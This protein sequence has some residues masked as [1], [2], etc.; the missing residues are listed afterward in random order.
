[1]IDEL[2]DNSAAIENPSIGASAITI[3]FG[4][5]RDNKRDTEMII[6]KLE[7]SSNFWLKLRGR[8]RF[9][10]RTQ[11]S[12]M[13]QRS[14][15]YISPTYPKVRSPHLFISQLS[16]LLQIPGAAASID[17]DTLDRSLAIINSAPPESLDF[18][19]DALSDRTVT[20]LLTRP[21]ETM[22]PKV[23]QCFNVAAAIAVAVENRVGELLASS[24]DIPP[25][26]LRKIVKV[27]HSNNEEV[28]ARYRDEVSK[29]VNNDELSAR[30]RVRQIHYLTGLIPLSYMDGM[31]DKIVDLVLQCGPN[32]SA[33]LLGRILKCID[34]E[35]VVDR[36][37][38]FLDMC[39]L[40]LIRDWR[41]MK[42]WT[43]DL[44]MA[45]RLVQLD[46]FSPQL[47]KT[48]FSKEFMKNLD[49]RREL[50]NERSDND[51][52]R[53]LCHLNRLVCIKYP[54]YRIPWFHEKYCLENSKFISGNGIR[55]E[56]VASE[57]R[58]DVLMH[59]QR[60]VGGPEKVRENVFT[61]FYYFLDFEV[62]MDIGS[63]I[64][65]PVDTEGDKMAVVP[66]S[67]KRADE[68][69]IVRFGVF[70]YKDPHRGS[71][72]STRVKE[73]EL[74]GYKAI[75][76]V[77]DEWNAMNMQVEHDKMKEKFF[78]DKIFGARAQNISTVDAVSE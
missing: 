32:T 1:M 5:E 54:Q 57:V 8:A 56:I 12:M 29:V 77:L 50:G 64:M 48:V 70:F 52:R 76:I 43:S 75:P 35:A 44:D 19:L 13:S 51:V 2:L 78:S 62:A 68:S 65:L 40:A 42:G 21:D 6:S 59:L 18:L 69:G 34:D 20:G 73:I 26:F 30:E 36:R 28:G 25:R 45:R 9:M 63:G 4:N 37:K 46:A 55:W 16:V 47:A 74:L 15:E 14:L 60:V 67:A 66:K 31:T 11:M 33:C 24:A 72:L 49:R 3:L 58:S 23:R 17:R 61:D 41:H 10:S 53:K 7:N 22:N 71:V 27:S 38:E 39:S